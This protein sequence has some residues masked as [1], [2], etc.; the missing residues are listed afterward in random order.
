MVEELGQ[1]EA[2]PITVAIVDDHEAIRLGFQVAAAQAGFELLASESNV[3]AA[4]AALAEQPK[5]CRVAV[6]DLSLSDASLV[7]DNVEKFV[8]TGIPVLIF[9]I[10]DKQPLI[11]AALKSGAAAV[12]SKSESLPELMRYISMVAHGITVNNT[13]TTAAIDADVE[14]KTANLSPREREVLSLYASGLSLKQVAH[15]MSIAVGTAKDYIDRVRD[16]FAAIDKPAGNKTEL[17]LRALEQ[18]LLPE[19]LGINEDVL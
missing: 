8:R 10:A 17:V 3:D 5:I 14:F 15:Q 19:R 16:K 9:S 11:R 7:A 2:E 18:G 6:L 12:V 1:L 13:H 4:L